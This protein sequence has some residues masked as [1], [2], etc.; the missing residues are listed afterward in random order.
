MIAWA[1]R[2]IHL[3][4]L[5]GLATLVLWPIVFGTSYDLR[6][7]TLGGIYALLVLG[8]QF[9]FGHAGALA[10]TQGTFFGLAAYVTGILGAR[11]GWTFAYT[12]PLSIAAPLVL[13]VIVA[14]P[15]L[16]LESHYFALAT[17]GIGQ[18]MWLIVIKW[19]PLTGGANGIP[20]V[21]GVAL[22]G[23]AVPR[24]WPILLVV[25]GLVVVTAIVAWQIMRGPYGRAFHVMR[26][27]PIAAQSLG[28]D[29]GAL[30]F[31]AFLL[32]AAYAGIAGA[33]YVHTIRVISPEVLEFHVMVA[34]LTMVV[35]GGRTRIAGAVLGAVLLVH[36]PEWFRFLDKYYLIA[37]GLVLLAAIIAAPDG[38]IGA[39]EQAR[40]RLFPEQ[41]PAPPAAVPLRSRRRAAA[42][43]P[44]TALLQVQGIT[45][46]FGGVRALDAV[47]LELWRGE[48]LGLIGPN[49]SGKTTL[50]NVM[51][52][53]YKPDGG[54]VRL[55]ENNITGLPPFRITRRGIARS[56]QNLALIDGMS[57]LDN[58][59][60]A[61]A[62]VEG[63]GL[64]QALAAPPAD[65]VSA[66]ARGQAMHL[67]EALGVGAVAMR[68]CGSLAYGLKRRVEIARALA[69]EPALLL[70]DE[71]AAG[72]NAA[73]QADLA[74]RLRILAES[75]L[76]L[77]VIEHNM[78]FLMP[79]ATRMI[80]LDYGQVIGE[81]TPTEIRANPR[82]IEAYLGAPEPAEA[83]A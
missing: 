82:V 28:L 49:G 54:T 4:L 35:V 69:L 1:S 59:A 81:G 56:F 83:R 29:I 18:V 15:V 36:I 52:G 44:A 77:L 65:P 41:P 34:C 23:L 25:W 8:Y 66:R 57:A 53:I 72:L 30:R 12:F 50:V 39:I 3:P 19:E 10:L 17:L 68:P 47:S 67:L 55:A 63:V 13:A 33:L 62:A 24:G 22:L 76:T 75:G 16:R 42:D 48:I 80:C 73:E 7:F 26:E 45:K 9:I 21:P 6:V 78:P 51:T 43:D 14:V 70:L 60:V 74:S 32:S 46:T 20:G 11:Y 58:V 31:V 2:G 37:Y 27:N 40:A 38:L 79:L 71:P 61:R 5:V 64:R